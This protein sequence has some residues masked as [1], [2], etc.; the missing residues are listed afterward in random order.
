MRSPRTPS[1]FFA[2]EETRRRRNVWLSLSDVDHEAIK[3]EWLKTHNVTRLEP[4]YS[5]YGYDPV[6]LKPT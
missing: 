1:L 5:R 2:N 4:G 6:P 3:Q